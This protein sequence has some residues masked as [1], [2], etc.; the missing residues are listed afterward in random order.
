MGVPAELKQH[1][2]LTEEEKSRQ[3]ARIAG[4]RTLRNSPLLQKFLAFIASNAANGDVS[5]F[6]IATEVLGRP[7]DFDS[8]TDTSVRTQAYR[9]RMKLKEYYESEGKSD[10]I[11]IDIPKG[12]YIPVFSGR[13]DRVPDVDPEQPTAEVSKATVSRLSVVKHGI[14][15][16]L[17]L[18]SGIG[19]GTRLPQYNGKAGAY[20]D[21][22]AVVKQ[23][24]GNYAT[25]SEIIVAYT[26]FVFLETAQGDLLRFRGGPVADRGT[27]ATK[28][29]VRQTALNPDLAA[30]A[31]SV[32]YEDGFTGTGEVVAV[33]R[34]TSMLESLGANVIVKRSRLVSADDLRTHDVIFLG[35]PVGNEALAE[36][37][38][39]QTFTFEQPKEPPYLWTNRI[40]DSKHEK[41]YGI[42]RDP[43]RS[44]I[45]ADYALFNVLPG[46]ANGKRI[47][48][49]AGLTTSG[50]QGAA[51]FA[52]SE[53]GLI[54]LLEAL[55]TSKSE[56]QN[57]PKYFESLLRVEAAKGLD[58]ITVKYIAGSQVQGQE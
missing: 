29:A 53:S 3:I 55:G 31:G 18:I 51:E 6:T 8:T 47:V 20:K 35:S 15:G 52:T 14:A 40:N 46:P 25:G 33:H 26:N 36:M 7:T 37:H 10:P 42:E 32:Y 5:E 41:S 57:F 48:I 12:H 34:L 50:T 22:P 11:I 54:R 2:E 38:L 45:R 16:L 23:F 4:S 44:V 19:L 39:S 21:V 24:W 56:G 49:L 43:Q 27:L 13:P 9:L 30:H 1:S 28:E 58:A 17:L